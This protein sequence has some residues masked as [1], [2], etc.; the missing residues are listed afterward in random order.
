MAGRGC[1]VERWKIWTFESGFDLSLI[2]CL[3]DNWWLVCT[4]HINE[5]NFVGLTVA[6]EGYVACGSE[7]NAVYTY[8]RALPSPVAI[9]RFS[10]VEQARSHVL[11][12]GADAQCLHKRCCKL[13]ESVAEAVDTGCT[14]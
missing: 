7:D 9:H 10:A 14:A 8:F 1:P 5:K 4:G 11:A 6:P 12:C 2:T 13:G 3:G